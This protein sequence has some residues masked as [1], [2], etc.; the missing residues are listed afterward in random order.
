MLRNGVRQFNGTVRCDESMTDPAAVAEAAAI[1]VNSMSNLFHKEV[2]LEFVDKVF[3]VMA[4]SRSARSGLTKRQERMAEYLNTPE[5]PFKVA[6][7][8]DC[9]TVAENI[10]KSTLEVRPIPEFPGYFVS[11]YGEVLTRDRVGSC[12]QCGKPII[13]E[14]PAGSFVAI[15]VNR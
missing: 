3:A 13:S 2:P 15:H 11:N 10:K 14:T 5:R 9:I 8:M 12:V 4:L 6:K 7:A 1:F